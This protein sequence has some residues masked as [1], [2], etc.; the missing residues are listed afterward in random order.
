MASVSPE[1]LARIT[2][3]ADPFKDFHDTG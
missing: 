2:N 1:R 3:F